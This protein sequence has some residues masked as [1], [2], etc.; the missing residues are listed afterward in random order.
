MK[1][2]ITYSRIS[3]L[4]FF[5]S[6]L[7]EWHFSCRP[8]YNK[9]W[10]EQTGALTEKESEAV[11]E[12]GE[13]M[14]KY[15]FE[16][17]KNKPLYLGQYF[18]LFSEKDIW[19]AVKK[20]VTEAEYKKIREIFRILDPRFKRIWNKKGIRAWGNLLKKNAESENGKNLMIAIERAVGSQVKIDDLEVHIIPSPIGSK[21]VAG[22]ANLG[23]GHV[24]I[25][26][27]IADT[28]DEYMEIALGI[29][30][31]EAAHVF[32]DAN[33]K[34]S[35]IIKS[36]AIKSELKLLDVVS[37]IMSKKE[38]LTEIVM[39]T[40]APGGYIYQ[41]H[42]KHFSPLMRNL[43]WIDVLLYDVKA[44]KEKKSISYNGLSYYVIWQMYPLSQYYYEKKLSMDKFFVDEVVKII[45]DI[46]KAGA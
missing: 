20:N 33:K 35:A 30:A 17:R 34:L 40:I 11:R 26:A 31:H 19:E 2:R 12:F 7:A 16:Y 32:L 28:S 24:T 37:P 46:K 39:G 10:I 38:I 42:A 29:M 44:L 3:S 9:V 6:N 25:E 5:I 1:Y 14:Q 27:S 8:E 18:F 15:G 22:G 23:Y 45:S 43:G 13:I 36:A 4:F 41:K 21:K